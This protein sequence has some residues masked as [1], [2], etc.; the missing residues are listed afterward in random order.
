M[1][2][3]LA[4]T[5]LSVRSVMED[6]SY[7]QDGNKHTWFVSF[8]ALRWFVTDRLLGKPFNQDLDISVFWGEIQADQLQ[9][10][11]EQY[12]FTLKRSVVDNWRHWPL[13]MVFG[14]DGSTPQASNIEI[15]VYFWVKANGY[16]WHAYDLHNTNQRVLPSYMFKGIRAAAFD[17][18]TWEC[19]W[20]ETAG[21]MRFPV[22][23]GECLDTW[24]PP[25]RD[26]VGGYVTDSGW[27]ISDRNYG[28]SRAE[29]IVTLADCCKMMD[30][31]K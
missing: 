7:R 15:D 14:S 18:G 11:F 27:F 5:L 12:G 23:I 6:Q 30:L 16:Y 26:P 10:A 20:E 25:R 28:Q 2:E 4:Q 13:Q 8:G 9:A 3:A 1:S 19:T 24:Y 22:S 29:K 17:R 21:T 31:L